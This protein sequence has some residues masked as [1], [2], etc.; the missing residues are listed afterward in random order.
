MSLCLILYK[1][2]HLFFFLFLW[3]SF[4]LG[5]KFML[6]NKFVQQMSDRFTTRVFYSCSQRLPGD[7]MII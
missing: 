2:P 1:Q 6:V 7:L 5:A 4:R 3:A